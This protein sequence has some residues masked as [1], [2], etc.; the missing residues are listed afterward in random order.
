M[1]QVEQMNFIMQQMRQQQEQQQLWLM[2]MFTQ[3]ADQQFS[4][5]VRSAD[6]HTGMTL[7]KMSHSDSSRSNHNLNQS[8]QNSIAKA[9]KMNKASP[10]ANISGARQYNTAEP[11]SNRMNSGLQVA[12]MTII[13]SV[14]TIS[15]GQ[16]QNTIINDRLARANDSAGS[17]EDSSRAIENSR[18]NRS[19]K[20]ARRLDGNYSADK[21]RLIDEETKDQ[22]EPQEDVVQDI[23]SDR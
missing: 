19:V 8:L 4:S 18:M 2:Q 7:D 16:Q 23:L 6:P 5:N 21:I 15:T 20:V 3:K 10:A 9:D 11:R 1:T 22:R 17:G 14:N 12:G 13:D